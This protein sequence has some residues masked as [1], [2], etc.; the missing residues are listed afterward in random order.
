MPPLVGPSVPSVLPPRPNTPLMVQAT[1]PPRAPRREHL[2]AIKP[3]E[4]EEHPVYAPV[5]QAFASQQPVQPI[6]RPSVQQAAAGLQA[7][8]YPVPAPFVGSALGMARTQ[9]PPPV[10]VAG[11]GGYFGQ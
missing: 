10:P 8:P 6:H 11:S 4:P 3:P 9:L 1:M 7:A 5:V 2:A